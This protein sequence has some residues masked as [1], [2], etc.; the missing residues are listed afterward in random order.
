VIA[1]VNQRKPQGTEANLVKLELTEA[2]RKEVLNA[3]G[4]TK[5]DAAFC[6]NFLHT[7][8][9][10]HHTPF[11]NALASVLKSGGKL[12]YSFPLSVPN[13]FIDISQRMARGEKSSWKA[14]FQNWDESWW[15]GTNSFNHTVLPFKPTNRTVTYNTMRLAY[16]GLLE[17]TTPFHPL[18]TRLRIYRYIFT[19][20]VEY[21]NFLTLLFQPELQLLLQKNNN[22]SEEKEKF[23]LKNWKD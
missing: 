17:K 20:N 6:F 13:Y 15:W 9:L 8:P 19:S 5:F 2:Y 14:S 1:D 16:E 11:L 3:A 10:F 22:N 7:L 12:F 21:Q 23:F 18:F 4:G